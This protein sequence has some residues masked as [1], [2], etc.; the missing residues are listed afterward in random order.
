MAREPMAA[1][2]ALHARP[3]GSQSTRQFN[4]SHSRI[5]TYT[6]TRLSQIGMEIS[7]I[8]YNYSC[9]FCLPRNPRTIG[10]F[11]AIVWKYFNGNSQFFLLVLWA[12]ESDAK[13][14]V[15]IFLVVCVFFFQK[16]PQN[17]TTKQKKID[18]NSHVFGGDSKKRHVF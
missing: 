15:G 6:D 18:D 9:Y 2:S 8:R 3:S 10:F 17:K 11:S 12:F 16:N 13:N 14:Q 4:F 5:H 7:L 1:K